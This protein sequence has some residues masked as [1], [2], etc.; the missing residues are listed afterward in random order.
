MIHL[1]FRRT[2]TLLILIIFVVV[3]GYEGLYGEQNGAGGTKRGIM[4]VVAAFVLFGVLQV[5][6]IYY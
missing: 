4:A 5:S 3:L 1:L 6:S 2:H